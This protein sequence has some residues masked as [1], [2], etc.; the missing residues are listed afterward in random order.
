MRTVP[1][2]LVFAGL[3][4]AA[5]LLFAQASAGQNSNPPSTA[6]PFPEDTST[7]PVL[8]SN[9]VAPAPRGNVEQREDDSLVGAVPLPRVD[10]DP[11]RS[12]DDPLPDTT[13]AQG[14]GWS[15]SLTDAQ[16]VL[17]QTPD[18]EEKSGKKKKKDKVAEE[19]PLTHKEQAAHDI[20]VGS[21]Y[22][23]TRDW[24]GALSRFESALVLD[25]ENP[26]VYW[27]LGDAEMH[28]GQYAQARDHL[29][30]LLLYDPENKHAREARKALKEPA[31]ANAQ[32]AGAGPSSALPNP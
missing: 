9:P 19:R 28:L 5:P 11:V 17:S 23:E 18:E 30:K 21:Y 12:P 14:T 8:P 15:S 31:L 7:V 3:L 27:G 13:G 25:P 6:N 1:R 10:L 22:L 4:A 29:Q 20:S 26:E 32:E 24:K 2:T 16:N